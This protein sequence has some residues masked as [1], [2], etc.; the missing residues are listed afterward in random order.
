MSKG[1]CASLFLRL[2]VILGEV[3]MGERGGVEIAGE[4]GGLGEVEEKLRGTW[5]FGGLGPLGGALQPLEG[6]LDAHF[7]GGYGGVARQ[8]FFV[9]KYFIE[10]VEKE[11][12]V[13]AQVSGWENPDSTTKTSAKTKKSYTQCRLDVVPSTSR[14]TRSL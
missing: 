12:N 4:D 14:V 13:I 6:F 3:G 1:L 5:D 9:E 8:A 2:Q 7:F 10:K 11:Q